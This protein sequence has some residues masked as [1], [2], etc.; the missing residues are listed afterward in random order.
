MFS[1]SGG[2]PPRP[3][4][5]LTDRMESPTASLAEMTVR[6]SHVSF[7]FAFSPSWFSGCGWLSG[8]EEEDEKVRPV[9]AAAAAAAVAASLVVVEVPTACWPRPLPR[10]DRLAVGGW[11]CGVAMMFFTE[12]GLFFFLATV[13]TVPVPAGLL[14]PLLKIDSWA[15]VTAAAFELSIS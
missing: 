10:P 5:F 1:V 6:K 4:I 15:A 2:G 11:Y 14:L 9:V 13:I 7:G 3:M 8:S 12:D